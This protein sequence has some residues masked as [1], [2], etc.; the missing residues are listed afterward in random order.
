M[1]R[2]EIRA[3]ASDCVCVRREAEKGVTQGQTGRAAAVGEEPK[4]VLALTH[5]ESISITEEINCYT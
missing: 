4:L 2:Q 3:A 5:R 1:C